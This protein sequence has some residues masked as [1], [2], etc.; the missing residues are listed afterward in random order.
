MKDLIDRLADIC[1]NGQE[2]K[3]T[4]QDA[5]R[6]LTQSRTALADI[7]EICGT[8]YGPAAVARIADIVRRAEHG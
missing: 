1:G 4:A 8:D 3:C 6:E 2:C 5:I 7:R